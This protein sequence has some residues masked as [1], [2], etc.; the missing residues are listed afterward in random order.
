MLICVFYVFSQFAG[1]NKIK[2]HS[3]NCYKL[4]FFLL[5]S[6][7]KKALGMKNDKTK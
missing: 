1:K 2:W 5:L 7:N 4:S 6:I 3:D